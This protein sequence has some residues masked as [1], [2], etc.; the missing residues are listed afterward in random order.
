[1]TTGEAPAELAAKLALGKAQSVAGSHDGSIVIGSDTFIAVE[2]ELLGKP[3][4]PDAARQMLSRLS[5]TVH[6]VHTGYALVL[7]GSDEAIVGT[8]TAQV[9]MAELSA[10]EIDEYVASGEPLDKAGAYAIHQRGGALID[11]MEGDFTA[12]VGLPL[13][14]V[15][16]GLL[17]L[18]ER[19]SFRIPRM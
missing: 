19:A 6:Q 2:A 4:S 16:Q 7:A 11:R 5:G 12:V 3:N 1:M 9:H 8:S 18:S 17:Q 14:P 10:D 15:R 13:R